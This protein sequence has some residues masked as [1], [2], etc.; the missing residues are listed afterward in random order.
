V[1]FRLRLASVIARA[2]PLRWLMLGGAFRHC[3][4]HRVASVST[5]ISYCAAKPIMS[6]SNALTWVRVA[7]RDPILPRLI[8]V[9]AAMDK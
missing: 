1:V 6:R 4:R 3:R 8:A 2:E 7:I 9:T 5:A